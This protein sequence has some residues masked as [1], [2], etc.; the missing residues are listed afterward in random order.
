MESLEDLFT[1]IYEFTFHLDEYIRYLLSE[2]GTFTYLILFLVIFCETGL[3][4]TPF[5]PGDSLLFTLGTFTGIG[6]LN[7]PLLGLLLNLAAILGDTVNYSI[8]YRIGRR[9]FTGKIPWIRQDHLLKTEAFFQRYGRKTIVIAR[10]VPI[11]RTYAP[12][13][14]GVARMPYLYFLFAN[15]F[16]GTLWIWLIIS[17]GHFFGNIPWVQRNFSTVILGIILLSLM[18]LFLEILR[19]R[20]KTRRTRENCPKMETEKARIA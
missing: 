16:G 13:V 10:F 12:F 17:L 4:I 6:A 11:V 5:L 9:A 7:F 8:G 19:A 14:A 1:K 3:V 2:F 20:L 15:I 18:P